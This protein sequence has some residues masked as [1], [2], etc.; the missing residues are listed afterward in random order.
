M[1]WEIMNLSVFG[2]KTPRR[3]HS[4][5]NFSIWICI[6]GEIKERN[7]GRKIDR[8]ERENIEKS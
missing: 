3:I 1:S 7:K 4:I 2:K 6:R 5:K 8:E